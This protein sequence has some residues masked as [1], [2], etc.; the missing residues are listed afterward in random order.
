MAQIVSTASVRAALIEGREMAL[1]DVRAR[2]KDA[3]C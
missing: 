2:A 1:L 3:Q